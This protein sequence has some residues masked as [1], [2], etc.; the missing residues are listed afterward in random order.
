MIRFLPK[1]SLRFRGVNITKV[2]SF[3]VLMKTMYQKEASSIR[4]SSWRGRECD[5]LDLEGVFLVKGHLM[6]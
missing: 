5:L 4:C 6:V 3:L 1:G 2:V